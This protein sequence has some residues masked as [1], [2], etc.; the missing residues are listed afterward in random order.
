MLEPTAKSTRKTL[1]KTLRIPMISFLCVGAVLAVFFLMRTP[2]DFA[3]DF[4]HRQFTMEELLYDFDYMMMLFEETSPHFGIIYRRLGLD[5]MEVAAETREL[6]ENYP[7]SLPRIQEIIRNLNL[8]E[9]AISDLLIGVLPMRGAPYINQFIFY[10]IIQGTLFMR[11]AAPD[12][13]IG[14]ISLVPL[15]R[16]RHQFPIVRERFTTRELDEMFRQD[17]ANQH[18]TWTLGHNIALAHLRPASYAFY[19]ELD[20]FMSE[21]GIVS[22]SRTWY[23][24]LNPEQPPT[25]STSIIEEGRIALAS[26]YSFMF[27]DTT[28]GLMLELYEF[29][30]EIQDYEHLIIDIR[31]VP[32]GAPEFWMY[33]IV[34]PLTEVSNDVTYYVFYRDT[35]RARE[36]ARRHKRGEMHGV[37]FIPDLWSISEAY[38]LAEQLPYLNEE[39]AQT[40]SVGARLSTDINN[41]WGAEAFLLHNTYLRLPSHI[42][43]VPFSGQIWLLTS[44]VNASASAHFLYYAKETD[45]AILVGEAARGSYSTGCLAYHSLPN[46][47]IMT[48]WD[49]SY[50]TDTYGRALDEYPTS[51]HFFNRA[52]LNALETVLEMIE[53]G[54]Y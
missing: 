1:W 21:R 18:M 39:D 53:E 34:Y 45:F 13:S 26:I 15:D 48:L 5:V 3:D 31:D 16:F 2:R 20:N 35:Q 22:A 47:G 46:T 12:I 7:E 19:S 10:N 25:L 41:L 29:Y 8:S 9:Q 11:F 33:G 23:Y 37:R 42:P 17:R 54:A 32:G 24:V 51:P 4:E 44:E 6:I 52:G 40:F 50:V 28:P 38:V 36:L 49:I 43:D 30:S 14:H 27:N